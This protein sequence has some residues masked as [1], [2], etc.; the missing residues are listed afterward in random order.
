MDN[1]VFSLVLIILLEHKKQI[2]KLDGICLFFEGEYTD[3]GKTLHVENQRKSRRK[4]KTEDGLGCL[5]RHE[6]YHTVVL[7][8][9]NRVASITVN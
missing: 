4:F 9:K 3:T 5:S 7:N 6:K 8:V 1:L 2:Q